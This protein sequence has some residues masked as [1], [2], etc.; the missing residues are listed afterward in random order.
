M[1]NSI[2]YSGFIEFCLNSNDDYEP[3]GY[4]VSPEIADDGKRTCKYVS[5]IKLPEEIIDE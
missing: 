2:N 3:Y 4:G 5:G 1:N